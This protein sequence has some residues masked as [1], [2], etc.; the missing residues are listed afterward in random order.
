MRKSYIK[1]KNNK[2]LSERRK[3]IHIQVPYENKIRLISY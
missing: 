3:Q 2:I 1:N